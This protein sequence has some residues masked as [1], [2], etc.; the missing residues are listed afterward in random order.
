[1][2][3]VGLEALS[4]RLCRIL[5]SDHDLY[6]RIPIHCRY[7]D[8]TEYKQ[9]SGSGSKIRRKASHH[10]ITDAETFATCQYLVLALI[11][12][13]FCAISQHQGDS[14]GTQPAGCDLQSPCTK[15]EVSVRIL[16]TSIVA[17]SCA[18]RCKVV[19]LCTTDNTVAIEFT[20]D[21]PPHRVSGGLRLRFSASRAYCTQPK[22]RCCEVREHSDD[23]PR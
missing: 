14:L 1:V 8:D 17:S 16:T 9:A 2:V 13:Y 6:I 18:C 22:L 4:W 10:N 12:W 23:K 20:F 7:P 11:C 21:A 5:S 19:L 15:A 3:I